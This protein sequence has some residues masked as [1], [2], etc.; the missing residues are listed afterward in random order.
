[1]NHLVLKCRPDDALAAQWH[2]MLGDAPFA[3]SYISPTYFDDPY[4][5]GERFA[6]LALDGSEVAAVVTGTYDGATVTSGLFSRPQMAVRNAVDPA[7]AVEALITGFVE[8]T[9]G[10]QSLL[11][12]HAW[13]PL[14]GLQTHGFEA[15]PSTAETSVVMIDLAAGVDAIFKNFSQ[16]RRNEL[17]KAE[18]LGVV[19]VKEPDTPEELSELYSIHCDWNRRKGGQAD[20]FEKMQAAA[21]LRDSRRIFIAKAEGRVIAGSFYRF[22]PGGVVEYAAN[23][24]LPGSQRLRPNDLI[25]WHAIQWACRDGFSHFSM[26]GSHLFL[27]RFG[28]EVMT[29]WRYCR[30]ERPI[31]VTRLKSGVRDL[32]VEAYRRLPEN[33]RARMRRVFA[34]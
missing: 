31:T 19:T 32:G 29:T 24:S 34:K 9:A 27:R 18:R 13:R 21:S 16:T 15:R 6:V 2:A 1:M 17:R 26:G 30:D 3:T 12:V 22:Y 4:V 33:L 10:R 23:F 7:A 11:E 5:R 25:G 14:N 20:S 8:I 28:G